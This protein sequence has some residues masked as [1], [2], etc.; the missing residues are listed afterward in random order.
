MHRICSAKAVANYFLDLAGRDKKTLN[1]MKIQKLVYLA[2]GWC[3]ALTEKPLIQ[4]SVEA[5]T[6]GPVISDL[7]H[8]FKRWGNGAIQERA[9]EINDVAFSGGRLQLEEPSIV[10]ECADPDEV[11]HLLER[12]WEVYERFT[13]IQLSNMTHQKGTPWDT[14]RKRN[15][16]KRS[17]SID[18]RSIR[19]HFEKLA[20]ENV[21]KSN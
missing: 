19:E 18:D 7:Y 16:G 14:T 1:P 5:W 11:K 17:V 3:L 12:V 21:E 4:E 2:H 13:A 15:A 20:E 10:D 9:T 6:Y 8:E